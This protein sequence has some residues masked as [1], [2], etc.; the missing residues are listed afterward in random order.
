MYA[1]FI[2]IANKANTKNMSSEQLIV[3]IMTSRC[4]DENLKMELLKSKLTMNYVY[5]KAQQHLS[6]RKTVNKPQETTAAS[7]KCR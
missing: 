4:P 5:D 1:E 2:K 7:N 6:A 3:A